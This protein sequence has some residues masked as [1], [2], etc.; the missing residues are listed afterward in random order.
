MCDL[1]VI[2]FKYFSNLKLKYL[3]IELKAKN[4]PKRLA[5]YS[6]PISLGPS[7]SFSLPPRGIE[8]MRFLQ[9]SL[10]RRRIERRQQ[11][12]FNLT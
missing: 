10:E 9:V 1:R 12:A 8:G 6:K 11:V 2:C 7:R 3:K 5:W 4:I